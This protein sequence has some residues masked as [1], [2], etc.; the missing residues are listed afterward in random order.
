MTSVSRV[1]TSA[2]AP[3]VSLWG[4]FISG[5]GLTIALTV[6]LLLAVTLPIYDAHWVSGMIPVPVV[7]LAGLALAT[8]F[9]YT[10]VS[11]LRSHLVAIGIGVLL[12]FLAGLT[13]TPQAS[14]AGLVSELSGWMNA[15]GT[16]EVRSGVVEFGIFITAV[17]WMLGYGGGW[18]VVRRHM[19]WPLVLM[20][21]VVL[22]LVLSNLGGGRAWD[23]AAFMGMSALLLIHV[24]TARRLGVWRVK[25]LAFD[26]FTVLSQSA[27]LLG[28]GLV[29]V[30]VASALPAPKAAPLVGLAN[31]AQHSLDSLQV[32]F[33]QLFNGLPS[34]R[35]YTTLI[36]NNQTFFT[37]NPHLTKTLLFEV[38]GGPGTYWRARSYSIYTGRG[39]E[40]TGDVLVPL[41][42]VQQPRYESRVSVTYYFRVNAATDTFFSAGNPVSVSESAQALTFPGLSGDVQQL[43]LSQGLKY[44]P[45]RTNLRY[46]TTGSESVATPGELIQAGTGYPSWVTQ[47]YLQLPAELPRRVV[48]LA[49]Q[50]TAQANTPYDKAAA[51]VAYLRT[52]PYNLNIP[53]PPQGM[54][55]V[56]YFLFDI[57]EGYCDYYASAMTVML[58]AVDVPARYVRGYASGSYD[59]ETGEYQ[60]L[61]DN[62][63][64]WVEVYFPNYGWVPFEPTPP[65]A[66]EFG[67]QGNNPIPAPVVNN[68]SGGSAPPPDQVDLGDQT[69]TGGNGGSGHLA[70]V[71]MVLI[72]IAALAMLAGLLVWYRW[73]WR[74]GRLS[75]ADELYA[76]MLRLSTVLG[77]PRR[78]DQ[79]PLEY[80]NTL[81]VELPASAAEI[82]AIAKAYARRRYGAAPMPLRDVRRAEEAW[83]HLRWQLIRRLF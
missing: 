43:R 82:R 52:I 23:L 74:L 64:A 68:T 66:A 77:F 44:F 31:M 28:F 39:W 59:L 20:S 6:G 72:S 46:S 49:R 27:F 83:G 37:G 57:R 53:G 55:G 4:R 51:I 19:G 78:Q 35:G 65:N 47:H 50:I 70:I 71:P 9:V 63:H 24:A 8:G 40:G 17:A 5:T 29:A 80:A 18:L 2:P 42:D 75:R 22:L 30:L 38:S 25:R 79:T 48:A 1:L 16:D 69:N 21:A 81:A 76:K 36:Y 41:K 12:V 58:R 45:T 3:P 56:D 33:S 73:W 14:I 13:L 11:T 32:R 61:D 54:D 60:V 15:V 7:A 62:Y 26:P 34:R 10:G 67:G